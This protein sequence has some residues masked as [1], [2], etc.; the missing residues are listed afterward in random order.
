MVSFATRYSRSFE[1]LSRLMLAEQLGISEDSIV[2]TQAQHDGGKDGLHHFTFGNVFGQELGFDWVFEAKLRAPPKNAGL[3]TFA[4]A[5]V[6]AFNDMCHGVVLTTNRLF[7]PQCVEQAGQFQAR[8]G[9]KVL[10]VDGPKISR[11]IRHKFE[12][13]R[14]QNY[15]EEFLQN[16]LWDQELEAKLSASIPD[17]ITVST[18]SEWS[19]PLQVRLNKYNVHDEACLV[20]CVEIQPVAS[21]PVDLVDIIGQERR[22][23]AERLAQS[24]QENSGLHLL[25]GEGGVGKS[26]IIGHA[27]AMTSPDNPTVVSLSLKQHLTSRTLFLALLKDLLGLDVSMALSEGDSTSAIDL[28]ADLVGRTTAS[29]QEIEA[30]V[31]ALTAD[32]G[33]FIARHDLNHTILL[34][35]LKRLLE[36]RGH[37]QESVP[38]V[39]TI[40]HELHYAKSEVLDFL[41]QLI[42]ILLNFGVRVLLEARNLD[43]HDGISD[44]DAFSYAMR[45]MAEF[46]ETVPVPSNT[47]ARNHLLS[48][49]PGLGVERADFILER[50]GTVPLFL[51]TAADFLIK[52]KAV[53]IHDGRASVVENLELFFEGITPPKAQ[54]LLRLTIEHW[55]RDA[56]VRDLLLGASLLD[57]VLSTHAAEHLVEDV[58]QVET[59]MDA[60]LHSNLF[61]VAPTHDRIHTRHSLISSELERYAKDTPFAL[62]RVAKRLLQNIGDIAIAPLQRTSKEADLCAAAGMPDR[63]ADLAYRAGGAFW[64]Q[65]QL[66]QASRYLKLAYTQLSIIT[67]TGGNESSAHR[68]WD[69]LF[70]LLDLLDQRYRLGNQQNADLLV[71]AQAV[72]DDADIIALGL[73]PVDRLTYLLRSGYILWRKC[74]TQELFADAEN[75]GRKLLQLVE[76]AGVV[77]NVSSDVVGNALSSLGIT[78]KA[79]TRPEESRQA[80]AHARQLFPNSVNLEVQHHSNEAALYLG[81]VPQQ[82]YEH[83]VSILELTSPA[84]PYFLAHLH[85]KVDKA[86]AEFLSR[87]YEPARSSAMDGEEMAA[88]NGIAAQ[89]ARALNVYGCCEW[90]DGNTT[91]AYRRFYQATLDAERSFSDRFL[92]RMRTNLA[93]V[94]LA[95]GHKD[96]AMKNASSAAERILSPRRENWPDTGKLVKTRW[97]HALV[98]CGA[99][100]YSLGRKDDVCALAKDVRGINFMEHVMAA[101]DGEF[102]SDVFGES[103][104]V[105]E[106]KI[107]I[108]G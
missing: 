107:M 6:V 78:L 83:Y 108:L 105:H 71:Q 95:A 2:L 63:A 74:H 99:V 76:Q 33:D 86:M 40:L 103:S 64:Q 24:L 45:N 67:H 18:A 34:T 77:Q 75:L 21:Q 12:S 23:I 41:S 19:S 4:K 55:A 92:W 31:R 44:W 11:W 93:S 84:S 98:Q 106:G 102:A 28:L 8:T 51:E 14:A 96:E 61:N 104:S 62:A 79:R 26:A 3:D 29:R 70:D 54:I 72:W 57:G 82:A 43:P 15:D 80:F 87:D 58:G 17:T 49:L 101:A 52:K 48:L 56:Q 94:A 68:R 30:T 1:E 16:L 36:K 53:V 97:Y 88:S 85:A 13:L 65:H 90:L 25:W 38:S 89:T 39:I 42:P 27:I 81:E 60:L 10:Y 100:L 9:L 46:E 37:N 59:M 47:D 91:S 50:V 32:T 5:M 73:K 22:Q 69:C 66:N 7:T 20:T 35:L